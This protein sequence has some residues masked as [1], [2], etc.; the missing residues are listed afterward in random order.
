MLLRDDRRAEDGDYAEDASPEPLSV[1]ALT[2]AHAAKVQVYPVA[3]SLRQLGNGKV[4]R[5]LEPGSARF[6]KCVG[7]LD[8]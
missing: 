1:A 2:L 8:P 6:V 3:N 5:P 7:R 4:F